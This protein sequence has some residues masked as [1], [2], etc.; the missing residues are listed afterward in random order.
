[1]IIERAKEEIERQR[2]QAMLQ[3]RAQ[4]A[5]LA[6]QVASKLI[7]ETL[8]TQKHKEL[9]EKYLQEISSSGRA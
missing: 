5:E 3:L 8:S 9:V 1:M 7:D 4:V 2:E 6:L